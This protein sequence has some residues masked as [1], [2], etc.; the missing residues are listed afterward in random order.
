MPIYAVTQARRAAATD[1][2]TAWARKK[3]QTD[4]ANTDCGSRVNVTRYS[5]DLTH[6]KHWTGKMADVSSSRYDIE[7]SLS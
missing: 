7:R 4:F 1:G 5:D 3:C 2:C 6:S